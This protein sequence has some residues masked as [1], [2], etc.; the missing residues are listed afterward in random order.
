MIF[1]FCFE[2]GGVHTNVKGTIDFSHIATC[3]QVSQQTM[4]RC[5]GM[6]YRK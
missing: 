1:M 5:E 2:Q 6:S 3:E 4:R